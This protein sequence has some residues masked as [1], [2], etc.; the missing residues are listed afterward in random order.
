MTTSPYVNQTPRSELQAIRDLLDKAEELARHKSW[1]MSGDTLERFIEALPF[2]LLTEA[3][4]ELDRQREE[5]DWEQWC[6]E[7]RD[8][9][10]DAPIVV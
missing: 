4:G 7:N 6:E 5:K 2:D 1:N 9:R 10:R 8:K 3:E